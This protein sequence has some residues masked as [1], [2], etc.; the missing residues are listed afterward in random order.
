MCGIV[1]FTGTREASP[2]LLEGLRRLEYR[3]YDSAGLVTGTGNELH[4]RKKAGR[5]AEL[6]KHLGTHPAPGCHGISHTRWATH[7]GATD[8]NS[9]PHLNARNDI[10]V[11]HNGVI[12]NYAALKHQLQEKG[13]AFRSDTDTEVLAHLI[14]HYYHGDLTAA[15]RQALA[16]VKGTYGIAVMAKA[17]PGVIVGAR[18]GSPLVI[19]VGDDG[20]YLASDANALA[21]FADKVVYLTDRQL[22]TLNETDW[23]IRDQDLAPVSVSVSDIGAFLGTGDADRGEYPHYM[24]KEIYEQPET[25]ANAMR[26]RLEADNATAH[27]GGL[28]LSAQQLRQVDRV[29]MTACGT[30]YHAAM[31]GEYLLEELARV[32]VEV[33]YASEFRYRN[34]PLDRSSVVLALTQSGETADT[35]AALRESKRM[36]H[37][38]LAICNAVGSSIAREADGGV[39]LHAGPEI[40]VAST[41]AFTSQVCVLTMLALYLGRTR[42]LSSTQGQRIIDDLHAL[43]ETVRKTLACHDHVKRVAEKYAHAKNV[44]YLGRQYLYPVALEGALK[45]KEISYIHAEGYPAAEMKHGPIALV[46]ESTP[47]VFLVPRGNVFDKVMSNMQEIKARGGPVIAVAGAGDREVAALADDVIPIPDVPE[48]LQPIVTA[49]PLQLLAYEIA[50]LC[51]CDVDKPRNLAKSVTV[52]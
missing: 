27:F 29:I 25:L 10:A 44:L 22:C 46:D 34:P 11:V 30:S 31:V 13:V 12:E 17:E 45:L 49:I 24:L 15:V 26:G 43:P 32:P 28:N 35:L 39:Y 47:S 41:K 37:T 51:G 20:T 33:E 8:R 36:G 6:A 2:I 50:L 5:L 16:L 18:L 19:G 4:V 23:E 21:G 1:G 42:H 40:G 3:G 48:Y 14:S 9:H 52:E 7:G 38:T